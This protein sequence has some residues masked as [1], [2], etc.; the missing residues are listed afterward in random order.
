MELMNRAR[1]GERA[2]SFYALS[3]LTTPPMSPHV[4]QPGSFP[5]PVL[6]VVYRGFVTQA[7]VIKSPALSPFS[8]VQGVGMKVLTLHSQGSFPWQL[9]PILR[10]LLK[11]TSLHSKGNHKQ[12]E[13][14][15]FR[16]GENICKRSNWQ[17]IH[18]QNIQPAHA[19]Q[20][21]KNQKTRSKNG[22]KT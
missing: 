1:C 20:Y 9:A 10:S 13:K 7:W 12:D 18:L 4:H 21:Q 17:R 16:M 22:Q 6:L 15:A 8:E 2:Q 5:N 14:T 19:A 11:V 3:G